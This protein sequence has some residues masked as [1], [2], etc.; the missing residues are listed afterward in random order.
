MS[1]TVSRVIPAHPAE[2]W[3]ILTSRDAMKEFMMGAEV[4][5]NWTV[6][7]PITLKGEVGGKPFVDRGEIRSFE[8]RKKLS[9]THESSAAPGKTHLVTFELREK[10]RATEV[11]VT[12]APEQGVDQTADEAM[13][14][15]YE[16][17][18]ATM[19]RD[20]EKAVMN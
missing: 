15:Q 4:H 13:K 18:W 1:A 6:G 8:P 20:L 3:E 14:A 7:Q 19:L 5:T 9:Y 10:G 17:T 11:V 16:K 2:V 12:Q